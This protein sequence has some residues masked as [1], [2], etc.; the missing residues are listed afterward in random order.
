[1]RRE[2]SL[3]PRKERR[4]AY[5][6]GFFSSALLVPNRRRAPRGPT[7]D[8][9]DGRVSP[10]ARAQTPRLGLIIGGGA[11][12]GSTGRRGGPG[13]GPPPP[14][15]PARRRRGG[16]GPGSVRPVPPQDRAPPPRRWP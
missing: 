8:E 16:A 2:R 3:R 1:M 14:P 6:L 10:L 12:G 5:S 15:P 7:G 9:A 4:G 13:F 11:S